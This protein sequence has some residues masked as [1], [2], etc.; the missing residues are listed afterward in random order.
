M[1]NVTRIPSVGAGKAAKSLRSAASAMGPL[2]NQSS[3]LDAGPFGPYRRRVGHV[4]HERV[5]GDPAESA[6]FEVFQCLADLSFGVHDKGSVHLDVLLQ[7]L[8]TED[9]HLELSSRVEGNGDTWTHDD[10]VARRDR[11]GFDSDGPGACQDVDKCVELRLP[12]QHKP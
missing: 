8:P 10:Q 4:W 12:R 7:R 11:N 9:E 1:N 5:R 3:A 6:G 2:L